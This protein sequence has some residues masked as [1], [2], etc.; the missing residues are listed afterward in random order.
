MASGSA[1]KA[2]SGE[3]HP[4]HT[5]RLEAALSPRRDMDGQASGDMAPRGRSRV[6]LWRFLTGSIFGFAAG[7]VLGVVVLRAAASLDAADTGWEDLTSVAASL[8]SFAPVGA[9][10]GGAAAAR[11]VLVPWFRRQH[12]VARL[13][14]WTGAAIPLVIASVMAVAGPEAATP[15]SVGV[16]L[17]PLGA[18]L[19]YLLGA[20]G[21]ARTR[22]RLT[23]RG[24]L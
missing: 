4:F 21:G 16:L 3:V 5:R 14:S 20:A 9:L 10:V 17:S 18:A 11:R 19:G 8:V 15:I 6:R 23:G 12:P 1:D 22:R 7:F 24:S 2:S 13:A